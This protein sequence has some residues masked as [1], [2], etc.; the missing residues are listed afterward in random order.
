MS[1]QHDLHDP[2]CRAVFEMLSEYLDGDLTPASCEELEEHIAGCEPCVQFLDS[3]KKTM[4][5]SQCFDQEAQP[6]VLPAQL[7]EELLSA[8]RA[9]MQ[10]RTGA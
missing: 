5:L 7:K 4:S 3:L 1:H 2:S 10:R 6:P 9:S 8:Y